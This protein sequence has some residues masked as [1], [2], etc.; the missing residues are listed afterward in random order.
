VSII[1]ATCGK[2]K[3][4]LFYGLKDGKRKQGESKC[5][6]VADAQDDIRHNGRTMGRKVQAAVVRGVF[7]GPSLRSG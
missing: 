4:N 5:G 3:G 1:P 6:F 2:F 7:R